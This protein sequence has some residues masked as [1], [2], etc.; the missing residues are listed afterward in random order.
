MNV[1]FI[2]GPSAVPSAPVP[3]TVLTSWPARHA[4]GHASAAVSAAAARSGPRDTT[5]NHPFDQFDQEAELG[6]EKHHMGA[7]EGD[8]RPRRSRR[9]G[10]SRA[11]FAGGGLEIGH[12]VRDMI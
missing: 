7:A 1:A 11:Q 3:A 6:Q 4:A 12:A 8:G 10:T 2:A 5:L 9:H